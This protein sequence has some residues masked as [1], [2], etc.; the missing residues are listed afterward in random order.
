MDE[1]TRD[2][3]VRLDTRTPEVTGTRQ[4]VALVHRAKKD[5]RQAV[6][7]VDVHVRTSGLATKRGR[8]DADAVGL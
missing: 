3:R 4:Y 2:V 5:G 1:R 8:E 6:C 7:P